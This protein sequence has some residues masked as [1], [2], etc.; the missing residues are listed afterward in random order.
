MLM[1]FDLISF[2]HCILAVEDCYV[3]FKG[4]NENSMNIVLSQVSDYTIFSFLVKIRTPEIEIGYLPNTNLPIIV[5][6]ENINVI[7]LNRI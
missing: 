3:S 5:E 4:A 1:S 7:G 6:H 2:V